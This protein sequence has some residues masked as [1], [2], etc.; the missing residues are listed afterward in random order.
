WAIASGPRATLHFCPT[1]V[2]A[3]VVTC[4]GLCPGLNSVIHHLVQ[5]LLR[6]YKAEKVFGIRGGF[7]GFYDEEKPPVELS[8]ADVEMLQHRPGSVLG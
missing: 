2:R 3:A 7:S 8:N 5:T 4:G 6:I 1:E